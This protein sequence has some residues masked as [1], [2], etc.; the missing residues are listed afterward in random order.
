MSFSLLPGGGGGSARIFTLEYP[1]VKNIKFRSLDADR[2]TLYENQVQNFSKNV[3]RCSGENLVI[4]I[5]GSSIMVIFAKTGPE[6]V[7]TENIICYFSQLDCYE[8]L[9]ASD[10]IY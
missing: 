7:I 6:S 9:N 1:V 2:M 8:N 4:I 3:L 5:F 10:I